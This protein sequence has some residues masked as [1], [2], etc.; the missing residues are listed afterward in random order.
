MSNSEGLRPLKT[1]SAALT[2]L[3]TCRLRGLRR[4]VPPHVVRVRKDRGELPRRL[5]EVPEP[6]PEVVR[7]HGRLG[8]A[9]FEDLV[10][11]ESVQAGGVAVY[12]R[13]VEALP[14][15]HVYGAPAGRIT[16][17]T[18]P[19]PRGPWLSRGLSF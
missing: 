1:G 15:L 4:I 19:P 17:T 13:D 8:V 7:G 10:L 9:P 11:H 16:V 14:R 3:W 18:S 2:A 5:S 6:F 12:G